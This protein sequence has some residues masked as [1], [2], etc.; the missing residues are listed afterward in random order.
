MEFL[1]GAMD[2]LTSTDETAVKLHRIY[3]D[4]KT[5]LNNLIENETTT[6]LESDEIDVYN[7]LLRKLKESGKSD[8][9]SGLI[10]LK[11][12][13]Y[14]I[15][16]IQKMTY[17]YTV[18]LLSNIKLSD[19]SDDFTGNG[20]SKFNQYLKDNNIPPL[21]KA[22]NTLIMSSIPKKATPK[23][24]SLT[25]GIPPANMEVVRKHDGIYQSGNKK[26]ELRPGYSYT[27]KETVGGLKV[28]AKKATAKKAPAKKAPA[29]KAT[30]KKAT[31][32]KQ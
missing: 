14:I 9:E 20:N 27:G 17:E 29:K 4:D 23:K 26:G 31:S 32:K 16:K 11:L 12:K 24:A 2:F 21:E 6:F 28:I 18:S 10:D 13:Y 19:Y 30:A 1:G 15:N 7:E 25:E 3:D 5:L 8:E 22:T